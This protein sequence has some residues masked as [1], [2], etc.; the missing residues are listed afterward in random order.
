MEW[1]E[2]KCPCHSLSNF[3][4]AIKTYDGIREEEQ[5]EK[6]TKDSKIQI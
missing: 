2:H 6:S 3:T 1:Q 4:K 5:R